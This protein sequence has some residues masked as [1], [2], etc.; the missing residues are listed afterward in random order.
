MIVKSEE[1]QNSS[2][3]AASGS[4]SSVHP[5]A[6]SYRTLVIGAK[7]MLPVFDLGGPEA[8]S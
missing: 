6:S 8:A 3:C 2:L 5:A 7:R 4:V 1:K